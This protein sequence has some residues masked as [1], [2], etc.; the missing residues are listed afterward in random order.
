[1]S[2]RI[3]AD[4]KQETRYYVRTIEFEGVDPVLIDRPYSHGGK[5][6]QPDTATARWDHG[7]QIKGILVSGA[8]LKK[9]GTAGT[10]RTEVSYCTPADKAHWG[11]GGWRTDAPKW[12][13]DLF[14]IGQML[15]GID[16]EGDAE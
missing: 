2:A 4:D 12:L 14:G 1:M 10:V 5:F 6:L 8:V 7:N 16:L 13:L 11:K 15:D 9:D 3:T